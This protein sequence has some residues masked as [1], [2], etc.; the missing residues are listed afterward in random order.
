MPDNAHDKFLRWALANNGA[1]E[2]SN[3]QRRWNEA[4]GV[5]ADAPWC[6]TFIAYGLRNAGIEP[7]PNPAY[8]GA[9][10]EWGGGKK[11]D[12]LNDAQAGDLLVFDWGDGGITDHVAAYLGNG[13]MIAGNNSNNSV[14]VSSVPAGNLVGI[15]RPKQFDPLEH[16]NPSGNAVNDVASSVAE[17]G[18]DQAGNLAKSIVSLLFNAVGKDG[19]RILLYL[20]LV[21]GG[22]GLVYYGFARSVGVSKP[23]GTPAK[24]AA[25][26]ATVAPK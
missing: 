12:N 10:L 24:A 15:V 1:S 7:P 4:A 11:V 22:A 20:A 21:I 23:V 5:S 18:K 17:F 16:V 3:R 9:W 14:G 25:A 19:A 26:A 8:S 13:Q 2:G 6:S